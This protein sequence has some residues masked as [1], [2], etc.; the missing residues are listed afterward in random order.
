MTPKTGTVKTD[1][2]GTIHLT[3]VI[4][5]SDAEALLSLLLASPGAQ[6]D[7]RKCSGAHTAVIQVLLALRPALIGPPESQ[8]LRKWVETLLISGEAG[9]S[10]ALR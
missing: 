5:L 6:V 9:K 7:W 8:F 2:D 1:A 3:G 10:G 4:A